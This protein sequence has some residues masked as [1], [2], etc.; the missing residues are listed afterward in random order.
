MALDR[1]RRPPA[2]AARLGIEW[3]YAFGIAHEEAG[4][5][6]EAAMHYAEAAARLAG[7]RG[8]RHP[9]TLA[10]EEDLARC[11]FRV[12]GSGRAATAARKVAERL[13]KEVAEA[14]GGTGASGAGLAAA[15]ALLE[16]HFASRCV[17]AVRGAAGGKGRAGGCGGRAAGDGAVKGKGPGDPVPPAGG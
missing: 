5:H 2:P 8:P 15:R 16:R 14:G 11:L 1:P 10:A 17:R 13:K 12:P 6:A 7:L 4:E 3:L 9:E